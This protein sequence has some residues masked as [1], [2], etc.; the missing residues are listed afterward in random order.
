MTDW[1][2]AHDPDLVVGDLNATADHRPLRNL[3]AAGYRSVTE[4]TNTGWRPTWPADRAL[5]PYPLVQ[6]DH[7]LVGP[8]LAAISSHTLPIDGSDH[9]GLLAEVAA[10]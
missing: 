10:K 4:L 3:S 6:V 5:P 8:R 7:V 1:V 9:R 2:R